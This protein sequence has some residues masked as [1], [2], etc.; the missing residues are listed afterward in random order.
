[1]LAFGRA[2]AEPRDLVVAP[3]LGYARTWRRMAPLVDQVDAAAARLLAQHP[4]TTVLVVGHS[5]G[6]LIWLEVLD[7]HPDWWPRLRALA[8]VAVPVGGTRL[9]RYLDPTGLSIGR[10]LRLDRRALAERLARAI[11]CLSIA[12]DCFL[13]RDGTVSVAATRF[14]HARSIVLP[15]ISHAGLVRSGT[16]HRLVSA[17]FRAPRP[18]PTDSA[19][20]VAR[21]AVL[22]GGGPSAGRGCWWA[23]T[24]LLFQDGYSVR[25][26]GGPIGARRVFVADNLGRCVYARTVAPADRAALQQT[27][28]DLRHER[29][30]QLV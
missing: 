16:V 30:A 1:M 15:R 9:G 5:L 18:P 13:G 27:L 28:R 22:P 3:D 26:L 29:A 23:R 20:I 12:G 25:L 4:A 2:L 11:P 7:R 10:D 24:V 19:A 14:A 17:F 6:G 21:L 8:L